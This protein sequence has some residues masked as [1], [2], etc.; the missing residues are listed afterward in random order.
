MPLVLNEEL[1]EQAEALVLKN[2]MQSTDWTFEVFKDK[3]VEFL[4][5]SDHQSTFNT[6]LQ[7]IKNASNEQD[8]I[9]AVGGFLLN[10]QT[11]EVQLREIFR[12][13]DVKFPSVVDIMRKFSGGAC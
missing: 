1:M 10:F 7:Y 4:D 11:I 5:N 3:V 13:E 8:L 9:A 6:L 12:A 2:K